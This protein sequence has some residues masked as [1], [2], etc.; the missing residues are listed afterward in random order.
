M[1]RGPPCGYFPEMTKSI[2]VVSPWNVPRAEAFFRGY[3][4]EIVTG[5]RYIGGFM[6]SK[7]AQDLWLG[8]K[9]EAWQDSV[10]TLDEVAR[11]HPQTAYVGL[12]KSFH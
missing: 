11:R 4:L 5:S 12:Q 6:W 1:V 10:A 2:L 7:A 9:V 3:G 8:G